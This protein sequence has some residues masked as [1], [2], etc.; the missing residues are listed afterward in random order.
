MSNPTRPTPP[1]LTRRG[2]LAA[3][4]A[5]AAGAAFAPPAAAAAAYDVEYVS[6]AEWG[7]DEQKRFK[8]DGA[9]N[10]PA[11]YCRA[12]ALTV[13][14]TDTAN[15]D[16]DPAATVRAIYEHHAVSNNWGDIGYHFLID[17]SG[18][19]Y[20]GRWSGD[21]GLPAHDR[22]GR[23]VTGFHVEGFNSGNLGIALLATLTDRPPTD[24]AEASLVRLVAAMCRFHGLDPRARMTY[25]NPVSKATREVTTLAG[26]RDWMRT[27]CPGGTMYTRLP[28]VREAAAKRATRRRSLIADR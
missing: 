8:A 25:S 19:I 11:L 12:Q 9:E 5:V 3:A 20:E 17:E 15:A 4:E 10:S 6:R 16:P 27:G 24:A 28:P 26:H 2:V 18:R 14:H 7:A 21:D 13:H 22:Q 1:Q 23:V